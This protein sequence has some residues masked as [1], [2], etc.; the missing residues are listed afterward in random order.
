MHDLDLEPA[1]A[2]LGDR[3]CD[4]AAGEVPVVTGIGARQTTTFR[5]AVVSTS[6]AGP[7]SR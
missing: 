4:E 5:M 7:L 6:H 1:D 3:V 2:Q